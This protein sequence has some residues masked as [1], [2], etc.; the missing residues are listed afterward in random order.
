MT[1]YIF[2]LTPPRCGSTVYAEIFNSSNKI[3]LLN[4]RGEGQ[5]MTKTLNTEKCWDTDYIPNFEE[6]KKDWGDITERR[7]NSNN[8]V[9]FIFEKSPPNILRIRELALA[10]AE[11]FIFA[12]NR[13]PYAF[14]SSSLSRSRKNPSI[15]KHASRFL[16]PNRRSLFAS[17]ERFSRTNKI[18]GLTRQWIYISNLLREVIT[19]LHLPLISYESLC[20]DPTSII[21]ILPPEV[22]S[23][24][25]NLSENLTV[26]V[27]DYPEQKISNQNPRQIS[28]LS[29]TDK[30]A[31]SK[32]LSFYKSLLSFYDYALM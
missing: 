25:E 23:A 2:L 30:S 16:S 8:N 29:D 13:N 15:M 12:S 26:N 7:Q 19:E 31:I 17:R 14:V 32:E 11:N 18:T 9:K 10:F 5:W 4:R 21:E 24:L 22:G 28:F 20:K 1:T 27:K 6:V 3:A